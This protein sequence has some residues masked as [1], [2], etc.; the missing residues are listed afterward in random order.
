MASGEPSSAKTLESAVRNSGPLGPVKAQPCSVWWLFWTA[1]VM[2]TVTPATIAAEAAMERPTCVLVQDVAPEHRSAATI[3][4]AQMRWGRLVR[5]DA[6]R[7]AD[8]SD[9]G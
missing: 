3:A 4:K 1:R 7:S 5:D 2:P 6:W 8:G 9:A